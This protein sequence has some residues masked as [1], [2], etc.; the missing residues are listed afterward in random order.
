MAWSISTANL[1]DYIKTILR[2]SVVAFSEGQC[3]FMDGVYF[4]IAFLNNVSDKAKSS[5]NI[6]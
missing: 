2:V 3:F 6:M 1:L 4:S 5:V